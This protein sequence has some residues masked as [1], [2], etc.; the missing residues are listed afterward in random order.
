MSA[1]IKTLG[2]ISLVLGI[3]SLIL[4]CIPVIPFLIALTGLI[5]G[6]IGT[7]LATKNNE[8]KGLVISGLIISSFSFLIGLVYLIFLIKEGKGFNNFNWNDNYNDP[9][10]TIPYDPNDVDTNYN[11]IDSVMLDDDQ[12][13]DLDNSMD[14]FD[15][16]PGPA[17]N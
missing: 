15:N 14:D 12:L 1:R 11:D 5:L 10:Y 4:F 2:T 3:V 17:P 16:T 13:N 6:I 9:I 8:Q 7:V